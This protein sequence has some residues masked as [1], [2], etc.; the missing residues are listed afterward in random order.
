MSAEDGQAFTGDFDPATVRILPSDQVTHVHLLRHGAVA[1]LTQRIVRGQMDVLLSSEGREQGR[2][3]ARWFAAR[4]PR[5]DHVLTSDLVRCRELADA[6]GAACGRA[7]IAEPRLREQHMGGWEGRTWEAITRAE[8]AAVTQYWSDYY[9][10]R[11][12]GGESLADLE[13]RVMQW[14]SECLVRCAG[15]RIVIV[16]HIGPIR[17]LLCRLLGLPVSEAL[18]FA[19]A[20][21]SHTSISISEAGSVITSMGERPWSF[22]ARD[23]GA[24]TVESR[25]ATTVASPRTHSASR[26]IALSGSAGTGKTTLGRKLAEELGVAFIE[27]RMRRR[28]ESGFDLHGMSSD[29]WRALMRDDWEA[30]RAD[31]ERAIDGFVSDRSSLD[32]AAF[33]LHYGLHEEIEATE[34]WVERMTSEARRYDRIVLFPWGSLPIENDGVRST[35]RWTQLRFQSILEG[36]AQRFASDGK[37][38][39]VP[40]TADFDRRFAFVSS[41]L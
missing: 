33:W 2:A 18:R 25:A 26:K 11:P 13:K 9:R 4:E 35:N 36:L 40:D 15:G 5:P 10:A 24:E 3:L 29:D 31:E 14:W 8:P 34:R 23:H 20:T 22:A 6:I 39:R 21:A 7:P 1:D 12:S 28:L 38:V 37:L 30:Q 16:A 32:Y 27:E 19:P 17:V 41:A